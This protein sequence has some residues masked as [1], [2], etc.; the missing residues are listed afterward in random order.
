[1]IPPPTTTTSVTFDLDLKDLPPGEHAVHLH[2]VARCDAPSFESAGPHLNLAG[3]EH[4]LNNPNG[5]H[6]GDMS[7]ITVTPSGTVKATI[8][9]PRVSA[10]AAASSLNTVGGAALVVH[11]MPDDLRS[12][13]AGNAGDRIAC[14]VIAAR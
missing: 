1:V 7:N 2:Q 10:G 3:R 14:G 8:A 9:N 4:G 12:D 11:A 13:P 6:T 5:P